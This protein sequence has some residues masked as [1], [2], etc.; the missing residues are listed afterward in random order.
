MESAFML[1]TYH[2][3]AEKCWGYYLFPFLPFFSGSGCC[4]WPA[5]ARAIRML[6]AS[7]AVISFL[8]PLL[9]RYLCS[10]SQVRQRVLSTSSPIMETMEWSVLRLQRVQ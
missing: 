2:G 3:G 9:A 1:A 10:L 5:P 7:W 8:P 4:V 6:N